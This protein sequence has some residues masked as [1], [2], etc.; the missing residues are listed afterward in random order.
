MK[1][2]EP[3]ENA[4]GRIAGQ[5]FNAQRGRNA[6][7]VLRVK[8]VRVRDATEVVY[9]ED[10]WKL[11]GELRSRAKPVMSA[12]PGSLLVG[13]A[14]RGDVHRGSDVDVALLDPLPPSI[15]E[16]QLQAAG[17][18][19]AARE[20]V[21]ATPLSTP[22]L[23]IYL[24]GGEK[25]SIPLAKLL[26]VEEEFYRFAGS[27]TLEQLERGERVQ[28]VNKRLLVI[29]PTGRGH[30]EFSVLG[31]EAEVARLLRVSTDTVMDRV[32][33]LMRRSERGRTG[34][35]LRVEIPA[36]ETPE[37]AISRIARRVPALRSKLL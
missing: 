7:R 19:I 22:K 18:L 29:I 1:H 30:L 5:P 23:Y 14:A 6:V 28:G 21:Q 3:L 16:E 15:A 32:Q 2:A 24:E 36:W 27:I 31:R 17:L 34:L 10:R 12:L 11:L 4:N 26:R 13:S 35:Y 9:S 8:P 20:L 25:A 37:D 33:A